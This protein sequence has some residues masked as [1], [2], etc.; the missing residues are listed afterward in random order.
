MRRTSQEASEDWW[1]GGNALRLPG[2]AENSVC[3]SGQRTDEIAV[4]GSEPEKT[5]V[6]AE[7]ALIR[8]P[9]GRAAGRSRRLQLAT[10]RKKVPPA[11][12]AV[13]PAASWQPDFSAAARGLSQASA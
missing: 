11:G 4:A 12:A 7:S 8:P 6:T 13:I 10:E 3:P 5:F 1:S 9:A 2:G